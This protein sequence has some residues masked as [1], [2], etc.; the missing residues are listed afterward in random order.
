MT[1][2]STYLLTLFKHQITNWLGTTPDFIINN[3]GEIHSIEQC[4]ST[5]AF[6]STVLDLC[7][8]EKDIRQ[9]YGR[10]FVDGIYT[11][12]KQFS[13]LYHQSNSLDDKLLIVTLLTKTFIIDSQLL[14]NH[15][16]FH[17]I[18]QMYLNLLIDKQLNLTFKIRLLDLLTFFAS[19]NSDQHPNW[20]NDLSRTLRTFT[21]DCFPLKSTEF[22]VGTQEYHDY[23]AAIRKILS[24]LELSSSFLLFELLIWMLCCEQHHQFEEEI[25]SSINRFVSQ[26]NSAQK[27]NQ[28]LD[29][30]FTIIFGK[31]PLFRIEHRLN[32]LEK[33]ILKILTSVRKST[34]IEFYKKYIC[35]LVID[36]LEVKLDFHSQLF[37]SI[38]INKI[39]TYRLIDYMYTILNK[40]DVF[41]VHSSIGRIFY[42]YLKKQEEA[43]KI[44]NVDMPVNTIK[45]G[46]QFD[47]KELTKYVITKARA[48]FVDSKLMKTLELMYP[49]T[50]SSE[51]QMKSHLLR[52]LAI[53]S[54]NCLISLLICTQTEAKLYKAFIFDANSTKDEY[55]FE[56]LIDIEHKYTFPLELERYYKKDK[57]TLL[58]ILCK[59]ILS[60][61]KA[62]SSTQ[63]RVLSTPKYL[64]SQYLFGSS[65][66]DELAVFDFTSAAVVDF[67]NKSLSANSSCS[68]MN[69][70]LEKKD[71]DVPALIEGSDDEIGSE[72]ID[73]EMDELNLHPCMVP[74]VCLLKHMETSGIISQSTDMPAW[75]ICLY[76]KFSDPLLAFNIKLFIMRL[77]IHTHSIF[78]PYARYW[79]T[80]IIQ[81]C[82]QMFENSSEGLNTFIIDTIVIILSWHTQAIPSELDSNSVQRLVEYLFANCSHRNTIV[83]KSNLDLI[84]KLV[85]CWKERI[86]APTLI[87]YKLISEPDP[88]SK[89]NAIGLSLIGIL[90]AN[91]I[92]PYYTPPAPSGNLPPVTTGSILSNL[93]NDLTEDKFHDTILKNLKNIYRNIYAAAAEV[94]GMLL[95]VK[96]LHNE[97]TQRLFDQ[98]NSILK[99][100]HNQNLTDTYVSCIYSV[101]KHYPQ[102]VDK[103]IMN[104]LVFSLKKMYGDLKI[105]C[106]ESLIPNIAEFESA[107]LE[108]RAAGILDI[109]I[110]KDFGI[111]CVALRLLFKLLSK[112]TH[113]QLYEIAQILSIDG[114]NECLIWTLEIYKWM[115]DYITNYFSQN[116]KTTIES[117]S[118]KFYHHVREQLL[119][120]LA[121]KNEYIR[122]NCRNF[123]C[124]A[125]RLSL[126]SQNR[127]LALVDQ[128]Y[129][130]KTENEYLN[131]CTNILLERATHNPDYQQL[132]FENP[133]DKCLF[134]EFPLACNWRQRHHTYMT[135]LFTL[136]SQQT[137]VD[138]T[139]NIN[140]MTLNPV[141]F[142]QTISEQTN[143]Q[144]TEQQQQPQPTSST[145]MI[146]QT[147][148][149]SGK[150]QFVPTQML[151]NT[152]NYNWLKQTNTL[153][154]TNTF[155][156]PTLAS[157][158]K[159]TTSLIVDVE[160]KKPMTNINSIQTQQIN[161]E[162]DI[163]DDIFRLKRRFLKDSGQLN[164][165]YFA[166]RQNEKKQ[167]EKQLLS[168]VKLKQE[169]QVEKYRTYRIGEL[170]DIQ[171]RSSDI[172]IPLQALAQCDNQIARLLYASLFTSVLDS[173]EEKLSSDEYQNL[174]RTIQHRFDVMLS[175]SEI[176]Y[177]SFVAALLDIVLSKREQIQISAQFISASTIASHLESVGI[178]TI[179]YFI[180]FTETN[181]QINGPLKKKLKSDPDLSQQ[182]YK[183]VD[184]WLELAKCYRSLANYDDVR[185]IFS[186]L[187]GLK[188]LTLRAIEEE[189]HSDFLLA[190][191]TYITALEQNPLADETHN[192]PILELEQEF[193]TQSMLNCCNQLNNWT[194]MSK[195]IFIDNTT[196]DSLWSNA[197]QL[198]YLMPFAIRSKMKLLISGN[199]KEQSEQNDLCQFFNNLSSTSNQTSLTGNAET[200]FVKRT[201]IEKQYPFELATFFLYQK[202]FDRAKYYIQYAK[203]QFLHRWSTLSR[204]SEY[205]RKLTVQFIQPYYELEQFIRFVEDNLPLIKTLENRYLTN[206]KGDEQTREIFFEKFQRNLLDQWQLPDVIRSSIQTWDDIVTNRAL[207]LDVR[208][209]N[210]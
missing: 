9:E 25:L 128:F 99:W 8:R 65:L 109:L 148:E 111:R 40:D 77:I 188:P 166:H 51:K 37:I 52:S 50:N 68:T 34:L 15:R 54:F 23:Q 195:H 175:Q 201:Y 207:F 61:S 106:L 43:R 169:N 19:I 75:M 136:Q 17:Q 209:S 86:R 5:V 22:P 14:L 164:A 138:S 97:S 131:Y 161:A 29:Y 20:S 10:Q 60:N 183:K 174:I 94:I 59:K 143:T 1:T 115:Y 21:A 33:L 3:V 196:F 102:I 122:V 125:K 6:L 172:L 185:G 194:I 206:N 31:N 90:L 87:L 140:L 159:K 64:S 49:G 69:I 139:T 146:L 193:W 93:P 63:Q 129:S 210:L 204:L 134:Q 171:I 157:Q 156:L 79:L 66:S 165:A 85:E 78:K 32:A 112:L 189:S 108:L 73:M 116:F 7:S 132:I 84:K 101:Q 42:D 151:E 181:Q 163:D 177:P 56:N 12:W 184:Q 180:R 76:K 2:W 30:M 118:E 154:A 44:L 202:D 120:L 26:L 39:C 114:P 168:E 145:P 153:D 96:K 74:M 144:S 121:C 176:F 62:D 45:I 105:E 197:H 191:N 57:R 98:L 192:D 127:L 80:P 149:I 205:G 13:F 95:N 123:W 58:N 186:Q 182:M 36:E 130:I 16:E 135:P 147:Q 83:M 137:N 71:S 203:E 117:V 155:A 41:G 179:E 110:H 38:L 162:E 160:K 18:S 28:L 170:P 35:S 46:E 27:Q 48:Q 107:Y 55:I 4:R 92:L 91:E 167:N 133:L 88:K 11:C 187:S 198:N 199:E 72:F 70:S 67:N 173:L 190:L 200:T 53:S 126:T 141:Q 47:G 150:Q 208:P 158:T 82:N 89:Q 178:L 152:M 124:D 104:K 103:S 100:F 142:M 113:E 24:A 81:M 119:Q